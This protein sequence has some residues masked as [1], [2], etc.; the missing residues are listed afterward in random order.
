MPAHDFPCT[1]RTYLSTRLRSVAGRRAFRPIWIMTPG[2]DAAGV[3]VGGG[4]AWQVASYA[5]HLPGLVKYRSMP[6]RDPKK[7]SHIV[8]GASEADI[9]AGIELHIGGQTPSDP[10]ISIGGS[11]SA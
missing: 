2:H 9:G 10:S 5:K 4:N 6:I 11:F 3:A 8:A 1:A 7:E